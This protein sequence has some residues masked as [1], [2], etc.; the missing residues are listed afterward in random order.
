MRYSESN[1]KCLSG[2]RS[3]VDEYERVI[4]HGISTAT[5]RTLCGRQPASSKTTRW[6]RTD[7][8]VN[9]LACQR[10]SGKKS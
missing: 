9:C 2:Y 1:M 5:G 3:D 6:E 8:A 4:V 7:H 10:S